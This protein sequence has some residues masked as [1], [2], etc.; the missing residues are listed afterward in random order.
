MA[1]WSERFLAR[2]EIVGSNPTI[3][4]RYHGLLGL[5]I[6][7]LSGYGL[8]AGH[9]LLQGKDGV[10]ILLPAPSITFTVYI[11]NRLEPIRLAKPLTGLFFLHYN[12]YIP[13][14]THYPPFRRSPYGEGEADKR[15]SR[16]GH[17]S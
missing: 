8:A 12:C 1:Q 3:P 7:K 5:N 6:S 14:D 11:K 16:T 4:S 9:S 2:E 13:R 10:R 15:P 17:Y